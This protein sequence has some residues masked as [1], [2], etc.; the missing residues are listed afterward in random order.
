[1]DGNDA[2]QVGKDAHE[3][4]CLH[5]LMRCS[6]PADGDTS[7]RDDYLDVQV[8]IGDRLAYLVVASPPPEDCERG[9]EDRLARC[10]QAGGCVHHVLLSYAAVE[11]P[12]G[13]CG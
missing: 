1:M 3:G 4:A 9:H 11:E 13:Q 8:G 10:S 2:S 5:E 12:L 6:I 7:M